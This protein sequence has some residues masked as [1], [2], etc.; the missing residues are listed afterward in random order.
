MDGRPQRGLETGVR[1]RTARREDVSSSAD[2]G[3]PES[4]N[5]WV[6]NV[7]LSGRDH[8]E[9]TISLNVAAL[10]RSRL[11]VTILDGGIQ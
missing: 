4:R 1:L 5:N 7:A 2:G 11:S 9:G 6:N 10:L 8:R 3:K